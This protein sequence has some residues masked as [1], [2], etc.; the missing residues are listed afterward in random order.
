LCTTLA[1][2]AIPFLKI[3]D[4]LNKEEGVFRMTYVSELQAKWDWFVGL[5]LGL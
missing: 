1:G 2:R 4:V 5:W 3:K